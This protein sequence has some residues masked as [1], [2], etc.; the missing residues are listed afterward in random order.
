[1]LL[2]LRVLLLSLVLAFLAVLSYAFDEA[3]AAGQQ[4]TA[5]TALTNELAQLQAASVL[6]A[7]DHSGE[8]PAALDALRPDYLSSLPVPPAGG[9][10]SGIAAQ[11][12]DW[13]LGRDEGV[14]LSLPEKLNFATCLHYNQKLGV[15]GIP[16]HDPG[17]LRA[18]CFGRGEPFTLVARAPLATPEG[19]LLASE[20]NPFWCRPGQVQY[21]GGCPETESEA[22]GARLL[23]WIKRQRPAGTRP[24]GGGR[25]LDG[26]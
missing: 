26:P 14:T 13:V 17:T 22:V 19:P 18:V 12:G 7:L 6:Y 23:R 16:F 15:R 21:A 4:A 20:A 25:V 3:F 24:D 5:V 9:Y 11:S 10:A 8:G 2:L 1:M